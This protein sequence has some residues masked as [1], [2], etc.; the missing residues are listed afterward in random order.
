MKKLLLTAFAFVISAAAMAQLKYVDSMYANSSITVTKNVK[1]GY[2]M[3]VLTGSPALDSLYMDIYNPTGNTDA[4]RPLIIFCHTGNFLPRYKNKQPTGARDDSATVAFCK[5]FAQKGYVVAAI[6]Y[7]LGWNPVSTDVNV[8]RSTIINAAYRGVQDLSAAIR[9]FKKDIATNGNA[10]ALDSTKIAVGGQGTGGYVTLA[11]ASLDRQSE[12]RIPKFFDFTTSKWMVQDSLYLGDIRG[13]KIPGTTGAL[14]YEN[15]KGYTSNAQVAFNFGGAMGDTSWLEAGEIPI[16]GAHSILDPFA[17]YKYGIVAVP[18]TNPPLTVVDVSGSYDVMQRV[19]KLGN[20]SKYKGK[21]YDNF[22][23]QANKLNTGIDGLFPIAGLANASAP[24]EWWA[25]TNYIRAYLTASGKFTYAEIT[26]VNQNGY[27]S[28]PLMSK[29]R[30]MRYVDSLVGYV[31]PRL[32]VTLGLQSAV[33]TFNV[34]YSNN[35]TLAPNPAHNQLT[36]LNNMA[37]NPLTKVVITDMNGR[38]VKTSAISSNQ[39]TLSLNLPA[40]LYLVQMQFTNGTGVKKLVI[41]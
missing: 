41:E 23:V 22:T 5:R 21:V 37:N 1:Y 7:R 40:G 27:K 6:S 19:D 11:Y 24:W 17:P 9:Y 33:N 2:G 28:N 38:T 4:K 26:E 35:V 25:D 8:R 10:F 29:A 13:F 16:I 30:A 15:H 31:A 3:T 12:I 36:I 14:V 18:G 20:N 32:A 34:D 39:S